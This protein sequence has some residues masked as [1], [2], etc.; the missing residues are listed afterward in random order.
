MQVL[1]PAQL[2]T[3]RGVAPRVKP[4]EADA[5]S[6][7]VDLPDLSAKAPFDW[8]R[9]QAATRNSWNS[10]SNGNNTSNNNTNEKRRE[11]F[12]TG[13]AVPQ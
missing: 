12:K 3:A 2:G 6:P 11:R 7:R 5:G 9:L 4:C 1:V 13:V 10:S 8:T